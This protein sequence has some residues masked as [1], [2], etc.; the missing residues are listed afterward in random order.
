M[1]DFSINLPS[2]AI[3]DGYKLV[4]GMGTYDD[5][6]LY[7]HGILIRFWEYTA[8]LPN[9]YEMEEIVVKHKSQKDSSLLNL[10]F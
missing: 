8:P 9:I 4:G 1:R 5:L 10:A 7:R 2:W 3:R 6:Y